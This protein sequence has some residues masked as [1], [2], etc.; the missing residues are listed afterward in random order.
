MAVY[1]IPTGPSPR[2]MTVSLL[3]TTYTLRLTYQ[4]TEVGGWAM[5]LGDSSGVPIACGLPLVPGHDILEQYGYLNIGGKLFVY[6]DGDP[7]AA[8]T[9]DGMGT[10][11]H[12]YFEPSS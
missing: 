2:V 8:P 6:T 1:E 10:L 7:G 4:D 5:D 12:L 11:S 9:F 3:G